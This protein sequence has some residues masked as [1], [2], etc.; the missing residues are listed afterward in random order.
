MPVPSTESDSPH[1]SFD[2]REYERKGKHEHLGVCGGRESDGVPSAQHNQV[3]Q[4]V[5]IVLCMQHIS[6]R[7]TK[8]LLRHLSV[9][10][11]SHV[12]TGESTAQSIRILADAQV[13]RVMPCAV[14]LIL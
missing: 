8:N 10:K 6:L 2:M 9:P 1:G 3:L 12:S 4:S 13:K 7:F 5:A 11:S 14:R